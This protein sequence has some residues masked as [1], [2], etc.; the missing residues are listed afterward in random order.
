[1]DLTGDYDLLNFNSPSMPD[2]SQLQTANFCR[3]VSALLMLLLPALSFLNLQA[4]EA[5]AESKPDQIVAADL[6][7]VMEPKSEAESRLRVIR[8]TTRGGST[9]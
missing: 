3:S 8:L 1:M 5:P 7:T 6:L 2:R 4:Q 9:G